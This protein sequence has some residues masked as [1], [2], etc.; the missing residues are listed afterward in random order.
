MLTDNGTHYRENF[1]KIG[2]E[3][4]MICPDWKKEG[5]EVHYLNKYEPLEGAVSPKEELGGLGDDRAS[6][7]DYEESGS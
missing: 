4:K 5:F 2:K 6:D 1:V 7:I 3:I